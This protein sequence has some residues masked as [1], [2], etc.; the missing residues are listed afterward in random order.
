MNHL[1]G[2]AF[3]V[4]IDIERAFDSTSNKSIKE[5]MIKRKVPE[6]FADWIQNMLTNRNLTVSF[7]TG[8]IERRMPAEGFSPLCYSV[9]W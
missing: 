5:D 2:C 7:D 6:A 8:S 9:L 1:K 3:G 4:F